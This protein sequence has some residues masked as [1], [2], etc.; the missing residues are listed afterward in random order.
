[1]REHFVDAL[2]TGWEPLEG[3]FSM[4]DPD[5]EHVVATAVVGG[6]GVIV[7]L[8]LKGFPRERV[9]G[10]IQVISPAEFAADTV[11]ASAAAAARAV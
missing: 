3:T 1:M 2:V 11:S 8:N 6:A 7:T 9:P 5:D 4:S 10:N